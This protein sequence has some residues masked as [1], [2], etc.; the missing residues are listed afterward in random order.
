MSPTATPGDTLPGSEA[1][2][3]PVW[4]EPLRGCP[5]GHTR[6]DSGRPPEPPCLSLLSGGALG[7]PLWGSEL[8]G[9]PPSGCDLPLYHA[10][11]SR[12]PSP[13]PVTESRSSLKH[14]RVAP[15]PGCGAGV[16]HGRGDRSCCH[17][18]SLFPNSPCFSDTRGRKS[19]SNWFSVFSR[20]TVP[21]HVQCWS[22]R[23][24]EDEGL[25][26]RDSPRTRPGA[27][28]LTGARRGCLRVSSPRGPVPT[29]S[30][31]R[32]KQNSVP[33]PSLRISITQEDVVWRSDV[34]WAAVSWRRKCPGQ[35]SRESGPSGVTVGCNHFR[36]RFLANTHLGPWSS[37]LGGGPHGPRVPVPCVTSCSAVWWGLWVRRI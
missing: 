15:T 7:P 1:Q 5:C 8:G 4:T 31:L 20:V 27:R 21:A 13:T 28:G 34:T 36:L 6:H 10:V 2:L 33:L 32:F 3:H 37:E 14:R 24:A 17:P 29:G 26:R 35:L 18:V 30:L 12:R 25:E 11:R 19:S 23:Q 16:R 9:P 22:L